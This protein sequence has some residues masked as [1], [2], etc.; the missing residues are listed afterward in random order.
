M[1]QIAPE[2]VL[3]ALSWRYATKKF[4]PARKIPAGEWARLEEAVVLS[5]SS[6]GLQPWRFVVVG[7]AATR[8]AL[9]AASWNQPQITDASHMVVFA[10]R[11]TMTPQDIQRH[12]DR[13]AEVR[14][15]PASTLDGFKNTMI[16]SVTTGVAGFDASVWAGRQ[17]YIALGILLSAAAMMGIDACP[18]EGIETAKYDEI[19]GLPAQGYAA[20]VVATLGYRAADD[21][22]SQLKK[23]R[24]PAEQ[25]VKHV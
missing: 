7:T 19:L 24:F 2:S 11:T 14:G 8:A 23:V 3:S 10:R 16:G 20:T 21:A 6:Y 22:F 1:Q 9:R 12:I 17:C 5:P 18:M 15:I 4:D 13:I 25:V